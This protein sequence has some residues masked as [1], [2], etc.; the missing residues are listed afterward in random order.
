[1]SST[2]TADRATAKTIDASKQ[3]VVVAVVR[4]SKQVA[5]ERDCD[6]TFL[7]LAT[8]LSESF[9]R[10]RCSSGEH[11]LIGLQDQKLIP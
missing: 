10:W 8:V 1:M 5:P 7:T 2:L 11:R 6:S 3:Q 4:L 9:A